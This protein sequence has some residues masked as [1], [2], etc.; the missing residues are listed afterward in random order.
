MTKILSIQRKTNKN[1]NR[2][3][4]PWHISINLSPLWSWS[5]AVTATANATRPKSYLPKNATCDDLSAF[6][7]KC[8]SL[9]GRESGFRK[10]RKTQRQKVKD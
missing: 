1:K 10:T 2:K 9:E 6:P 7:S 5:L 3:L 4:W 8:N